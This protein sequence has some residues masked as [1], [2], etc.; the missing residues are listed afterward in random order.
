MIVEYLL[1]TKYQR[2]NNARALICLSKTQASR[3]SLPHQIQFRL[4]T[5]HPRSLCLCMWVAGI[6]SL[7]TQNLKPALC[8]LRFGLVLTYCGVSLLRNTVRSSSRPSAAQR[9]PVTAN[10]AYLAPSFTGGYPLDSRKFTTPNPRFLKNS[11][12]IYAYTNILL[13]NSPF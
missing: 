7:S 12:S 4:L 6:Q 2:L 8:C 3:K 10:A 13:Q 5:L 1:N 11:I 9:N